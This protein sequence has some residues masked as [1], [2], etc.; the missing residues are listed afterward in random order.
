[1]LYSKIKMLMLMWCGRN[2]INININMKKSK[3]LAKK[4]VT[5]KPGPKGKSGFVESRS[6]QPNKIFVGNIKPSIRGKN[7]RSAFK[8]FGRIIQAKV[9]FENRKPLCYGYVTF[10]TQSM[11]DHAQKEMDSKRHH[12]SFQGRKLQVKSSDFAPPPPPP[13]PPP[14][15]SGKSYNRLNHTSTTTKKTVKIDSEKKTNSKGNRNVA[16]ASI[17]NKQFLST[18]KLKEPQAS[19]GKSYIEALQDGT[20]RSNTLLSH[21]NTSQTVPRPALFTPGLMVDTH[22]AH[23]IQHV[24][25]APPGFDSQEKD[26]SVTQKSQPLRLDPPPLIP[27]DEATWRHDLVEHVLRNPDT[28][29][30][31]TKS[32]T[33]VTTSEQ[34]RFLQPVYIGGGNANFGRI[35]VRTSS[36]SDP[37]L[38]NL[39]NQQRHVRFV[40]DEHGPVV[41]LDRITLH[42]PTCP[43]FNR[44]RLSWK[45]DG[46]Q[47]QDS[48]DLQTRIMLMPGTE[49]TISVEI[50]GSEVKPGAFFQWIIVSLSCF[51]PNEG[52]DY[53]PALDKGFN[54]LSSMT[55]RFCVGAPFRVQ[56]VEMTTKEYQSE[57]LHLSTDAT[58]FVPALYK[59][60]F[61][62][63]PY[64][65]LEL[66]HTETK[67]GGCAWQAL[68]DALPKSWATHERKHVTMCEMLS[69]YNK[70][71]DGGVKL[72]IFEKSYSLLESVRSV[73]PLVRQACLGWNSRRRRKNL[74][75]R[76]G[77]QND[78]IQAFQILLAIE[79]TRHLKDIELFDLHC[80]SKAKMVKEGYISISVPGLSNKRPLVHE[81]MRLEFSLEK[82]KLFA[83]DREM[84]SLPH[85]QESMMLKY[86]VERKIT[87]T[88]ELHYRQGSWLGLEATSSRLI[89]GLDPKGA[90]VH[91]T[92]RVVGVNTKAESVLVQVPCLSTKRH[93]LSASS[94]DDTLGRHFDHMFGGLLLDYFERLENGLLSFDGLHVRFPSH[95]QGHFTAMQVVVH[96][97]AKELPSVVFSSMN[98]PLEGK[99]TNDLWHVEGSSKEVNRKI[100]QTSWIDHDL[101]HRQKLAVASLLCRW[102]HNLSQREDLRQPLCILGPA[103]TGKTRTLIEA[104]LQ[105]SLAEKQHINF[106]DV[107]DKGQQR[108][109]LILVTAPTDVAADVITQRLAPKCAPLFDSEDDTH[110]NEISP[111]LRLFR[112]NAVT[113]PR[114]FVVMIETLKYCQISDR[115]NFILPSVESMLNARNRGDSLIVVSTCAMAAHL[116][117]DLNASSK[118]KDHDPGFD[119]IFVDEAAQALEPETL[120]SVSCAQKS[121]PRVILFG[122]PKQLGPK[123]RSPVAHAQGLGVSLLER[124]VQEQILD[125]REQHSC[126]SDKLGK[127]LRFNPLQTVELNINYRSHSEI[128]ALSNELFYENQL[129]SAANPRDVDSLQNYYPDPITVGKLFPEGGIKSG[130]FNIQKSPLWFIGVDG[131]DAHD[132]DSPSFYN[133]AE[134]NTVCRVVLDLLKSNAVEVSPEDFGIIAPYWRQVREIRLALRKLNLS[135]VRVGLVEDYQGQEARITIVSMTLSRIRESLHSASIPDVVDASGNGILGSAKGFNV[136]TSR[137]KALSVIIG[138][139]DSLEGDIFGRRLLARALRTNRYIGAPC[140]AD[141]VFDSES[142]SGFESSV[143]K[144]SMDVVDHLGELAVQFAIEKT[145]KPSP[146]VIGD[147]TELRTSFGTTFA[148]EFDDELDD[149]EEYINPSLKELAGNIS[150]HNVAMSDMAAFYG[151]QSF[152][153]KFS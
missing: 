57:N 76:S 50:N 4:N 80:S 49:L 112:L 85:M 44:P 38:G 149:D 124:L 17:Q 63:N 71:Q 59:K 54:I 91:F 101:N 2:N 10:A 34:K 123:I 22:A 39:R 132:I 148:W 133:L 83:V 42:P 67:V 113:R 47:K 12:M 92:G 74:I 11:A 35:G 58:S 115:G 126:V 7:L 105:I 20:R 152:D 27:F 14:S 77:E 110:S 64:L 107:I 109:C 19:S 130:C 111:H 103:G 87:N 1:M 144:R 78:Y 137:A 138:N 61:D 24:S 116:F 108:G 45:Q 89:S 70:L 30:Q 117:V 127:G 118:D 99:K 146:G 140:S 93:S 23:S 28:I 79:K 8:R 25:G 150:S 29:L 31:L 69:Y 82:E 68:L 139:P 114:N 147:G 129:L 120:L 128:L 81:N 100:S 66:C 141:M 62:P 9:E 94:A 143:H 98:F 3:G 37:D 122:D 136:A 16:A 26:R 90:F 125:R 73:L 6:S 5:P 46:I 153:A 95:S 72:D 131:Q 40:V 36:N 65:V 13:P 52:P 51:E 106:P 53:G 119:Y 75:S 142:K 33:S 84:T 18:G 56:C 60:A 151:L 43:A 32:K 121:A 88:K 21:R 135:N 104:V 102:N 145:Q 96:Y 97:C 55:R 134:V 48:D 15:K 86:S 41:W